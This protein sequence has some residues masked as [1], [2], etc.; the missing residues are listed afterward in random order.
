MG[1]VSCH[2]VNRI[3]LVCWGCRECPYAQ[4]PASLLGVGVGP[5]GVLEGTDLAAV[6]AANKI[7]I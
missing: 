5:R 7:R 4:V 3:A 1:S 6:Q 2:A